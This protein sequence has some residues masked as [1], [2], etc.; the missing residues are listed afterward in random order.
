[1][2]SCHPPNSCISVQFSL[3]AQLCPTLC[4]P[5]GCSTPGLPV[6]HQLSEF[7]QTHVHWVDDAIEPSHPLLSP[8][9]PTLKLFQHQ[10]LFKWVS[11]LHQ[12]AKV[13]EFQ[14]QHQSLQWIFRTDFLY[15]FIYFFK[16]ALHLCWSSVVNSCPTIC[17]PLDCSTPG[18]PIFHYPLEFVQTH[19][20][21][22]CVAFNH[23]ILCH[24]LLLLLSIFSSIR[25]FVNKLDPLAVQ[26]MLKSLFQH[27]S[28][29]ASVLQLSV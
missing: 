27:H 20:H 9:S 16:T 17:D 22:V 13:L 26:G 14:L 1:M 4:D 23:L 3:V 28:S 6:H 24:S 5:K 18:F 10:R 2:P 29:K 19:V 8:S 7:T 21:W 11:S 15:L 12:A 25:V